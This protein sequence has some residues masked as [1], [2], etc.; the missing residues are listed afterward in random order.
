MS[1]WVAEQREARTL[2]SPWQEITRVTPDVFSEIRLE[3]IFSCCKWD[4][5][6]GD[7]SVLA[8]FP[9]VLKRSEWEAI[10]QLAEQLSAETLLAEREITADQ[11]LLKELGL[12]RSARLLCRSVDCVAGP[13]VSARIMRFDFHYTTDGWKIS[14]ANTDVPGGLIEA[15]GFTRLIARHYPHLDVTGDPDWALVRAILRSTGHD[16]LIGLVHAT[17]YTDDRQMMTYLEKLFQQSGLRTCLI[18]PVQLE[19]R[20]GK[21][22]VAGHGRDGAVDLIYRFFPADW[23]TLLPRRHRWPLRVSIPACNPVSA[24]VTQSKRFP[25]LWPKLGSVLPAWKMLLPECKDVRQI[26]NDAEQWVLKPALGRV[27]EDVG[28]FGVTDAGDWVRILREARRRP[29]FWV[30]QRRFEAIPVL[31]EDEP[32]YPCVGV[33]TV[34]GR[35]AGAY[36][37]VGHKPLIDAY[38]QDIAVLTTA[39]E[40]IGNAAF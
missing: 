19:W 36:G 10:R 27:G 20:D 5:Q 3:T 35:V 24:L 13:A 2:A 32:Y 11:A 15:G 31:V 38:A 14:E 34:D 30:A 6:V 7:V 9:L 39:V 12:T 1:Q 21:S 40:Q 37:R 28:I 4:P 18:S 25:L 26:G 23:L 33:Y 17:A 22:F 16:G 8:D 29:Q